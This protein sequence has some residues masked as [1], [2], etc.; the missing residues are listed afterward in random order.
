MK[1]R[2]ELTQSA[3]S[4]A[5]AAYKW[6]AAQTG[7]A[8]A[9]FDALM[10]A[11]ESLAELPTRC[12]LARESGEFDEPVRQLL[13]RKSPHVYRVLFIVRSDVVYVLHIRHSARR[14]LEPGEMILPP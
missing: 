9:W 3:H 7:H 6:L 1:Y 14:A 8:T 2:V 5:D 12:P 11:I 10:G 13:Y 4:D